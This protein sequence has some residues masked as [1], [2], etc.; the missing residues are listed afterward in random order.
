MSQ[1]HLAEDHK[2]IRVSTLQTNNIVWMSEH[3]EP[4][5]CGHVKLHLCSVCGTFGLWVL[6]PGI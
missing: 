3:T 1:H 5:A 6:S 2:L 4:P